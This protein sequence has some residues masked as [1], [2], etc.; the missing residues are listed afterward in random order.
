[1][2]DRLGNSYELVRASFGVLRKDKELIAFPIISSILCVLVSASFVVPA[3]QSGALERTADQLAERPGSAESYLWVVTLFLFYFCNYFVII[4]C[5]TSLIG[6]ALI[7]LQGGDPTVR[8]GVRI[9]FSRI[10]S[11]FRYA[12]IAATVGLLLRLIE[13]RLDWVGR[14][15][16][17]IM[18]TAWSLASYLVVPVIVSERG[19]AWRSLKRSASLLRD[20]WGE[21]IIGNFGIGLFFGLMALLGFVPLAGIGWLTGSTYGWVAAAVV[22]VLY[23]ALL[24]VAAAAVGGIY[25]AAVYLY[26]TQGQAPPGFDQSL[27]ENAFRPKG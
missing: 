4:F 20:T 7:R 5:N 9:A 11:I 12:V 6:A 16:T 3:W 24:G 1:M 17:A 19:G 23:W 15:V 10:G 21:Q 13:E 27:V 22:A 18:G 26:A 25:T 14:I 2:F 8:D